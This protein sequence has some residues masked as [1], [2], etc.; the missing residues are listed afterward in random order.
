MRF[1]WI[2]LAVQVLH[3]SGRQHALFLETT[4]AFPGDDM[5]VSG[6]HASLLVT[7]LTL[8]P[9]CAPLKEFER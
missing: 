1:S 9:M 5:M 2:Q 7:C 8:L 4:C 6:R 3:F